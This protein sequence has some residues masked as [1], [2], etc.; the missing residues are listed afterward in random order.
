MGQ[1]R[2]FV[3]GQVRVHVS[4]VARSTQHHQRLAVIHRHARRLEH[5][6]HGTSK[7][8]AIDAS[9]FVPLSFLQSGARQFDPL[10]RG[11]FFRQSG[12]EVP[13][14]IIAAEKI[15]IAGGLIGTRGYFLLRDSLLN[16]GFLTRVA[17]SMSKV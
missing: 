11:S 17:L 7:W 1:A 14:Q 12:V 16:L 13:D 10:T 9:R 3:L 4:V 15:S 5:P 8:R 6:H 2:G